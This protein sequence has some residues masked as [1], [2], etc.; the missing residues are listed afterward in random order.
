MSNWTTVAE[1]VGLIAVVVSLLF[2]GYEIKRN[3]D[4]GV[5]EAQMELLV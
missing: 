1:K 3:N 4:L 5:V 2:V